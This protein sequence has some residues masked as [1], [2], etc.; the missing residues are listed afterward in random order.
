VPPG[1]LLSTDEMLVMLLPAADSP[2]DDAY[3]PFLGP[4]DEVDETDEWLG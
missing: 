3:D 1:D 2:I 4:A